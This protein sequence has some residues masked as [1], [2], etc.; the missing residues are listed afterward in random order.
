MNSIPLSS[1][2]AIR[3]HAGWLVGLTSVLW[4]VL[5]FN[6][7][8]GPGLL[9]FTLLLVLI[10]A[11]YN[12]RFHLFELIPAAVAMSACFTSTPSTASRAIS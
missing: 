4:Y 2:P 1:A 11:V 10:R 5:L 12:Q 3:Q 8:A 6:Q 9:L 7:T